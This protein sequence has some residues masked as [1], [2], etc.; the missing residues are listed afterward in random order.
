[1]GTFKSLTIIYS[2]QDANISIRK[3]RGVSI[4]QFPL[5]SDQ[6]AIVEFLC[7]NGLA[8]ADKEQVTFKPSGVVIINCLDMNA[9]KKLIE[10]VHGKIWFGKKLYCNGLVPLTPKKLEGTS[11][12]Q[13]VIKKN[14]NSAKLVSLVKQSVAQP[15]GESPYQST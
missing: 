8:E 5:D 2:S 14:T 1:M 15:T 9:I 3:I 11:G 10:T 7:N 6:G 12:I 13:I 4:K